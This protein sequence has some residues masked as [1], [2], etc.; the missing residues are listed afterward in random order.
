MNS[1]TSNRIFVLKNQLIS[2]T[3]RV[4][5]K[6]DCFIFPFT[7]KIKINKQ[8]LLQMFEDDHKEFRKKV[9]LF[10]SQ[11]EFQ[12]REEQNQ[13]TS[14]ELQDWTFKNL[15]KIL[16]QQFLKGKDIKEDPLKYFAFFESFS[17]NSSSLG[18]KFSIN[19]S[20]FTCCLY[21]LG[22]EEQ[23]NFFIPKIDNSEVFGCFG[24]TE[25]GHGSDIKSLETTA[26]F[27][28]STKEIIINSPKKSSR[29]CYIG[30]AGKHANY[31]IIFANLTLN[32]KSYGIHPFIV[33]LRDENNKCCHGITIETIG[34][35]EGL[36]GVDHGIIEFNQVRI[37]LKN[38]LGKF[39]RI[40]E[41][42]E[43][44][45]KIKS[46]SQRFGKI[47]D[48]LLLARLLVAVPI[49]YQM[50]LALLIA[51]RY[52][53][54]RLQFGNPEVPIISHQ[55]QKY[56]LYS[57]L[58]KSYAIG[59]Y[60][61]SCKKLYSNK[62]EE[63][64]KELTIKIAAAK[65]YTSWA[66]NQ[67]LQECRE[68]CGSEGYISKNL[69]P[70]LKNDLDIMVTLDGANPVLSQ[71]ISKYLLG[72][73]QSRLTSSYFQ[74]LVEYYYQDVH[75]YLI[76]DT[77]FLPSI[78]D[79]SSSNFLIS[80]FQ[81]REDRLVFTLANR[82]SNEMK[83]KN[84]FEAWNAVQLHSSSLTNAY[85]E[86]LHLE[87]FTKAIESCESIDNKTVLKCLRT[88]YAVNIVKN[89]PCHQKCIKRYRPTCFRFSRMF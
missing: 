70:G 51:I 76:Q 1:T 55:N 59:F 57:N 48:Q 29:K 78:D 65:I 12:E 54:K 85:I 36:N 19:Y 44:E 8:E 28:K 58:A 41:N 15:L 63:K 62:S 72:K 20:F 2:E 17:S 88:L 21:N 38:M 45:T 60:I 7:K 64:L 68:C 75:S 31:S 84:L 50:R 30:G 74:I 35:K 89:D 14:D 42:G 77:E 33:Q 47:T 49:I 26:I 24:M 22:N 66:A 87:E 27:D 43:Y 6:E 37:P 82:F 18:M 4:I 25:I 9:K 53:H 67:C 81:K 40:N 56:L 61:K 52:S 86:K 73:F 46:N 5:S 32:E 11:E 34:K 23:I 10:L 16:E 3:Q 13:M 39:G 79:W 80:L 83:K 71:L 69:I